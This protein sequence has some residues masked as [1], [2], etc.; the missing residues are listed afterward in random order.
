MSLHP[1][2]RPGIEVT[3]SADGYLA[4]LPGS[5]S[6]TWLNRTGYLVLEL[7][8]GANDLSLI[9]RAIMA[10]FD[11]YEP[12]TD[13]VRGAVSELVAA[14]LVTPGDAVV[15][16][17]PTLDIA[18]WAAGSSIDT[19]ALPAVHAL[20]GEAEAAGIHTSLTIDRDRSMRGARNR[21][22]NR[23]ISRSDATHVLL[24]DALPDPMIAISGCNIVQ[25][26]TSEHEAIGIPVPIGEPRWEAAMAAARA[27]PSLTTRD[28]EAYARGYDVSIVR[29]PEKSDL[30]AGFIEG[31][32]CSSGALLL[33]RSAV[34]RIAGSDL[35]NRH[36][37]NVRNGVVAMADGRGFF[38]TGLS[39]DHIDID[40]DL[41]FCER[42]R[43][44]G[45]Q[46]MIDISGDLGTCLHVGMHLQGR[47]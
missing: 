18:V 12:P 36:R 4:Q 46:L 13:A 43:G 16:D 23:F 5:A 15:G 7:C 34:E 41:A 35:A 47:G 19:E 21:A 9:G 42:L 45:G 30:E 17:S 37:G 14:G 6:V 3:P 22:S 44:A 24:L 8:T 1:K 33:R 2:R 32:H 27:I 11:L 26:I 25:L 39:G 20:I 29:A 28:I 31:R 40:E 10:A 38:D